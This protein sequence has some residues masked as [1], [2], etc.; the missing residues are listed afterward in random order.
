M[1]I[2]TARKWKAGRKSRYLYLRVNILPEGCIFV[3]CAV[4][5]RYLL[6]A[7]ASLY[8]LGVL[9]YAGKYVRRRDAVM[10]QMRRLAKREKRNAEILHFSNCFSNVNH[11]FAGI[12][13]V[14]GEIL[15]Y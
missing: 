11:T 3:F 7:F 12:P 4:R 13:A 2:S 8:G 15:F 14:R 5:A 10:R 9:A 6:F 1:K